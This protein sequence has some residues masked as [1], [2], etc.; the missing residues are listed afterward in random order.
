MMMHVSGPSSG[1]AQPLFT[2]RREIL[3]EIKVVQVHP[4]SQVQLCEHRVSCLALVRQHS[5]MDALPPAKRARD[6][7]ADFDLRSPTPMKSL[8]FEK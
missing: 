2:S 5:P 6:D 4:A 1:S 3:F 8:I 7:Q